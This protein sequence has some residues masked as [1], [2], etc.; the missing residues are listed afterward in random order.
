MQLVVGRIGRAHGIKGEVAVEVRTDEPEARLAPGAVLATDPGAV[1]PL[2][3]TTVRAHSGRLLLVFEGVADRS[4]AEALRGTML[5][6]EVDPEALPG[7]EDEWYDHQLVGL[8][9]VLADGTRV[10]AV[11][12][13]LHLPGHDLLAVDRAGAGDLL[14]PFV[15]EIVPVVDVPGHRVVVAPP[16]GL[17]DYL[18]GD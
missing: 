7:D 4:A 3:V 8:D 2:T 12:E 1:G 11:R 17:I 16:D 9:V 15:A 5:L 6:A 10:G 13:V 14:V 18:P